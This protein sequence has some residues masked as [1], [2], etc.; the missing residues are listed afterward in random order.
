MKINKSGS[1]CRIHLCTSTK[2]SYKKEWDK[3]RL[4]RCHSLSGTDSTDFLHSPSKGLPV[5]GVVCCLF[6]TRVHDDIKHESKR[7]IND[8]E[9]VTMSYQ[10]P[11]K[12]QKGSGRASQGQQYGSSG[13]SSN[14]GSSDSLKRRGYSA[15]P[16]ASRGSS[17][18]NSDSS[19]SSTN[20]AG[21]IRD[22]QGQQQQ[23]ISEMLNAAMRSSGSHSTNQQS[24]VSSSAQ[25]LLTQLQAVAG[26]TQTRNELLLQQLQQLVQPLLLSAASGINNG[27]ITN[28]QWNIESD[29][30]AEPH[31][32]KLPEQLVQPQLPLSAASGINNAEITNTQ[33]SIESDQLAEPHQRKLPDPG[34]KRASQPEATTTEEALPSAIVPC[35]ARG[36]PPEHNASV[37]CPK[38]LCCCISPFF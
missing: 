28:T 13:I 27:E 22:G 20:G 8:T 26:T 30:P 33:W 10:K 11:S 24:G 1:C 35:R 29:Q 25:M 18:G 15:A 4:S 2:L 5:G 31:Q 14:H 6:Y 38:L 9:L 3:A 32:R 34:D 12:R 21:D 37:R 36:M 19:G 17:S 16:A 7:A 23:L